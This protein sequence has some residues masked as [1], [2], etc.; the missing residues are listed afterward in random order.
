[1]LGLL[2]EVY[3]ISTIPGQIHISV[4]CVKFGKL[5]VA[6]L[7]IFCSESGLL[8]NGLKSDFVKWLLTLRK[9]KQRADETLCPGM[10]LIPEGLDIN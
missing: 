7:N 10:P 9:G 2:T 8:A 5:Q 1:M 4:N 3:R 6:Y